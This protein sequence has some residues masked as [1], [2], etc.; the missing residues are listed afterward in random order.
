MAVRDVDFFVPHQ[1]NLNLLKEVCRRLEM[2]MSKMVVNIQEVGNT[3]SAS[4][5]IALDQA[6]RSGLVRRG[7]RLLFA[8]FGAGFSWG[9]AFLRY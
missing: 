1:S 6:V 7:H 2:P 8:S 4:I 5:P 3:S 9:S